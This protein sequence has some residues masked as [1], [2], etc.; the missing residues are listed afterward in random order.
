MKAFGNV[1]GG[2]WQLVEELPSGADG[3]V[4]FQN[5]DHT[6]VSIQPGGIIG[7][8]PDATDGPWE[9]AVVDGGIATYTVE[10][11]CWPFAVRNA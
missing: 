10:G 8:R 1:N 11:V 5:P 6:I 9:Q 2:P 7:T 4:R 3:K